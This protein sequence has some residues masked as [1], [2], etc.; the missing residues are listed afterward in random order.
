MGPPLFP[1]WR[2]VPF[3]DSGL[4]ERRGST[5][6]EIRWRRSFWFEMH[7]AFDLKM[8]LDLGKAKDPTPGEPSVTYGVSAQ[9]QILHISNDSNESQKF[10]LIF[11]SAIC[12][13]LSIY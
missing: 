2:L 3:S 10:A 6:R 9:V 11:I 1:S 12:L 8:F 4:P 13:L 7:D 5:R